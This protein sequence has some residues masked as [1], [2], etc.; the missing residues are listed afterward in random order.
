[1]NSIP[2]PFGDS[3]TLVGQIV[4]ETE[5]YKEN[6]DYTEILKNPR[7]FKEW[8]YNW[9]L[10]DERILENQSNHTGNVF[11]SLYAKKKL[12]C[13]SFIEKELEVILSDDSKWTCMIYEVKT[14]FEGINKKENDFCVYRDISFTH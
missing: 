3:R 11:M 10:I 7:G 2:L 4:K 12:K 9:A 13:F 6:L 8:L 5:I 1:M 14:C